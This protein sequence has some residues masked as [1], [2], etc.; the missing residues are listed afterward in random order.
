MTDDVPP[1]TP[2]ISDWIAKG[3]SLADQRCDLDWLVSDWM[4][5]GKASGHLGRIKF[6]FLSESVGLPPKRLKDALK[7]AI[8]FP[9]SLRQ[10]AVS[11]DHHAAVASLPQ[12]LALPLLKRAL[13]ERLPVNAMREAV[14][15]HRF[16]TGQNFADE[17]ADS[18]LATQVI[19]AWNRA[20]PEAR[21]MAFEHFKIAAANGLGIVDEDE[22][23]HA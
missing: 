3:R 10:S 4:A 20:T 19:R 16:A 7:A 23:A 13:D 8:T 1:P 5:E 18:T 14:T 11:A 21:E 6:P 2:S 17:D 22:P 15:Q 9:P 12:D